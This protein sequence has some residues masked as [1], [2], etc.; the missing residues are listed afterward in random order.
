MIIKLR[1]DISIPF[2]IAP[3][4][5]LAL[6]IFSVL[7]LSIIPHTANAVF[8]PEVVERE[9]NR[10]PDTSKSSDRAPSS[11]HNTSP[12]NTSQASE[13]PQPTDSK[14][15]AKDS[16][17]ANDKQSSSDTTLWLVGGAVLLVATLS[18]ALW[19]LRKRK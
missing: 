13:K 19:F 8:D 12:S 1:K 9:K 17:Q 11:G 18:G 3:I 14:S 2:V 16:N 10:F 15:N 6:Y 7:C 4:G 5:I